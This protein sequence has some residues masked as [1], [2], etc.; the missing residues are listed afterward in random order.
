[1]MINNEDRC[2][3]CGGP[4]YCGK[5]PPDGWQLDDGRSVCNDCSVADL[6]RIAKLVKKNP[7]NSKLH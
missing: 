6:E 4:I 7:P 5:G 2:D 3:D 1:M